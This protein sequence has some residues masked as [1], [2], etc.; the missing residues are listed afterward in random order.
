[1]NKNKLLNLDFPKI[2]KV[3]VEMAA[4]ALRQRTRMRSSVGLATGRLLTTDEI[5]DRRE[6]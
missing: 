1:M 5:N 6:R 3:T 4:A 2:D